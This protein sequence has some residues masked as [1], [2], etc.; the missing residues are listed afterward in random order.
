MLA[1]FFALILRVLA[2][3]PEPVKLPELKVGEKTY[4]GVTLTLGAPNEAKI[5]HQDGTRFL[6]PMLLPE[7]LRQ[8]IGYDPEQAAVAAVY[9][10]KVAVDE[11]RKQ[12][13]A[14]WL[15]DSKEI[16]V[17]VMSV[18]GTGLLCK[19][20]S[21]IVFVETTTFEVGYLSDRLYKF[22]VC[23]SG[24]YDYTTVLGASKTVRNLLDI[25]NLVRLSKAQ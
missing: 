14:E 2:A 1:F 20:G 15:A 5:Q 18:T 21:E 11:A 10:A 7:E 6:N 8:K 22:R 3:D 13:L 16:T 24:V 12:K 25:P 23:E 17:E 19:W 9:Q 4:T